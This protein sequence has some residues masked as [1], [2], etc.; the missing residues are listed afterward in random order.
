MGSHGTGSVYQW[1][2]DPTITIVVSGNILS[3]LGGEVGTWITFSESYVYHISLYQFPPQRWALKKKT[4]TINYASKGGYGHDDGGADPSRLHDL[5]PLLRQV[6]TTRTSLFQT[7][8]KKKKN[9]FKNILNMWNR[10]T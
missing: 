5:L 1:E 4:H 7:M 10:A 3:F 8:L 9:I 2:M 6:A